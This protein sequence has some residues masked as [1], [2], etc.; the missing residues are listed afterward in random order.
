MTGIRTKIQTVQNLGT[1]TLVFPTN[2]RPL[3]CV[4]RIAN[5]NA[6]SNPL[7][8]EKNPSHILCP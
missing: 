7:Q 6:Q 5:K 4:S 2:S 8:C 3:Y 1:N